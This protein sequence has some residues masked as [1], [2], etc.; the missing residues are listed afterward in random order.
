MGKLSDYR[1][2]LEQVA[3][4]SDILWE[5]TEKVLRC[6]GADA[7][8]YEKDEIILRAG[9]EIRSVGI[10]LD[11]TVQI[12][13]EDA[14]AHRLIVANIEA[15][16]LFGEVLVCAGIKNSPVSAVAVTDAIVMFIGFAQIVSVCPNAC[17]FHTTLIQNML[18]LIAAKN[19][20]LNKKI[21]Y[22]LIKN[23]R[24]RLA[25]YLLE[26]SGRA[27]V[28]QFDIPYDRSGLA[29][30]LNADRSALSRELGRMKAAGLID[31]YK[32]SFKLREPAKLADCVAQ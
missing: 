12:I 22:L 7:K 16:E 19:L 8:K 10:V 3:L 18:R 11:G 30:Y 4:F 26:Q 20:M 9:E 1:Q 21:D 15:G 24:G 29:D 32:N 14:N 13:K 28:L 6:L 2:V 17:V 23:L 27:K 25:A 31:F 5:N